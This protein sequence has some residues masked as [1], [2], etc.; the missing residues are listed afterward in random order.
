MV[1][2]CISTLAESRDAAP[3]EVRASLAGV[4][5]SSPGPVDPFAGIVVEPPNLG[6]AFRD[7]ALASLVEDSLGLPTFL[8]RDTNVAALGEQAYGAG[9]G[10]DDFLY[11]TVSTGV[12]GAIVSDGRLVHG[13]DGMAGEV[14]HLPIG[15]D[16]PRCGCGGIAHL[17]AYASGAALAREARA[18]VRSGRSPFLAERAAAWGSDGLD[19]LDARDVAEGEDKGDPECVALMERARRSFAVACVGLTNLFNPSRIIVGGSIAEHQGNRLLEPARREI[20]ANAFSRPAARVKLVP[21]EL[22]PDVSLAGALPLVAARLAESGGRGSQPSV[23]S[24]GA[25]ARS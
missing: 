22:G 12:G 18:L 10:C 8:D 5:I 15:F 3:D 16:G 21:A 7:V 11:I 17:E 1:D 9:R 25:R 20:E 14:G 4:G 13:P 2:A 23:I 6:V 19:R 24:A